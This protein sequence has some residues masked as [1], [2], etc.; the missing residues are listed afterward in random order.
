MSQ[1]TG[2]VVALA[3]FGLVKHLISGLIENG[4]ISNGEAERIISIAMHDVAKGNTP[5]HDEAKAVLKRMYLP[6]P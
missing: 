4:I 5:M 3:A 2:D 1:G 6:A